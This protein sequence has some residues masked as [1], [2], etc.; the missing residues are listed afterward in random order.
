MLKSTLFFL[1]ILVV[2]GCSLSAGYIKI[3]EIHEVTIE[4]YMSRGEMYDYS[5][6]LDLGNM[7]LEGL[8][9]ISDIV[10]SIDQSWQ[11][12]RDLRNVY[13]VANNNTI[14]TIPKEILKIDLAGLSLKGNND[15]IVPEWF[16]KRFG[17]LVDCDN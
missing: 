8:D 15:F 1:C 14:K 9:G 10:V 16:C 6:I 4:L 13:V 11:H 12:I 17:F 3:E 2:S 7:N 5:T